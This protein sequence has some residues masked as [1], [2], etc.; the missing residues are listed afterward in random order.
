MVLDESNRQFL[1]R[2]SG[3]E[4]E[5]FH[6]AIGASNNFDVTE[7]NHLIGVAF[8]PLSGLVQGNGKTRLTGLYNI[9]PKGTVFNQSM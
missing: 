6:R 9:V 3:L 5:V 8:V 1:E 7:S 2:G 4:F